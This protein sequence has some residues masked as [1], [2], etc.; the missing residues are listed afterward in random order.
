MTRKRTLA[1]AIALIAVAAMVA[2]GAI[3]ASSGD[4]GRCAGGERDHRLVAANG[5][6]WS[7]TWASEGTDHVHTRAFA[8]RYG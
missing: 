3:Y 8:D 4:N 6:S 5:R 1:S 2:A 7:S